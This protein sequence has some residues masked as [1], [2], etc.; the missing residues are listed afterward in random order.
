MF[1]LGCTTG[2]HEHKYKAAQ[3]E[4]PRASNCPQFRIVPFDNGIFQR[5]VVDVGEWANR[6][7]DIRKNV[8]RPFNLLKHREG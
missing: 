5:I 8:E 4:S 6:A 2:G 3:G 1:R 7:I